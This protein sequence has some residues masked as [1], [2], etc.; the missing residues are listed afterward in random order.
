ME[1]GMELDEEME[2]GKYI[3]SVAAQLASV[4]PQTLRLY[5]RKGLL[6]PKRSAKNRRRYSEA[7]ILRLKRIQ[8]LTRRNGLNLSGV[9]M[10][11]E[12]EEQISALRKRVA[13]LEKEME[14]DRREMRAEIENLKRRMALTKP[15]PTS[16]AALRRESSRNS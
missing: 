14:L 13:Q 3:I 9:R 10:V 4:H 15:S 2:E 7:D 11:L 16:L 6:T 1:E 8:K 5:E 12:L